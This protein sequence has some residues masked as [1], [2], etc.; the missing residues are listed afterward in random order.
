MEDVSLV[1]ILREFHVIF[2][3]IISSLVSPIDTLS[4]RDGFAIYRSCGGDRLGGLCSLSN[5]SSIFARR[6]TFF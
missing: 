1:V 5:V 2:I 4:K 3:A 6:R